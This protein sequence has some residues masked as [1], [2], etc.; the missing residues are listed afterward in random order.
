MFVYPDEYNGPQGGGQKVVVFPPPHQCFIPVLLWV[1]ELDSMQPITRKRPPVNMVDDFYAPDDSQLHRQVHCALHPYKR[2]RSAADRPALPA[3]PM[4]QKYESQE[5]EDSEDVVVDMG[6]P[7]PVSARSERMAVSEAGSADGGD[8][9]VMDD[10][11]RGGGGQAGSVA[12]ILRLHQ[13]RDTAHASNAGSSGGDGGHGHGSNGVIDGMDVDSL[14]ADN[15][16]ASAPASASGAAADTNVSAAPPAQPFPRSS[17]SGGG[18]PL[19]G[20][21][22]GNRTLPAAEHTTQANGGSAASTATGRVNPPFETEDDNPRARAAAAAYSRL[23]KAKAINMAGARTG[24]NAVAASQREPS[25]QSFADNGVY[26]DDV[27]NGAAVEQLPPSPTAQPQSPVHGEPVQFRM[28]NAFRNAAPGVASVAPGVPAV[29]GGM[30]GVPAPQAFDLFAHAQAAAAAPAEVKAA[31]NDSDEPRTINITADGG[32]SDT[33]AEATAVSAPQ[34]APVVTAPDDSDAGAHRGQ[35][36][37][38]DL[39]VVTA[40][41]RPVA[42]SPTVVPQHYQM[43]MVPDGP[44]TQE[45]FDETQLDA[46]QHESVKT[47]VAKREHTLDECLQVRPHVRNLCVCNG[48]SNMQAS[49][50]SHCRSAVCVRDASASCMPS[51]APSLQWLRYTN[52][53]LFVVHCAGVHS[54]RAAGRERP[55]GVSCVPGACAG[56]HQA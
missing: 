13:A 20:R 38:F 4:R 6:P 11:V 18:Q 25:S 42:M 22:A 56:A 15:A 28:A 21:T 32:G 2:H 31:G 5:L 3:Q 26:A 19:G 44:S 24:A 1:H 53:D 54:S 55:V 30:G 50:V 33:E 41:N 39:L 51:A 9:A 16:T 49:H 52:Q 46:R 27:A 45:F 23:A 36:G 8:G 10:T 29:A 40:H 34:G 17:G 37:P 48:T 14:P 35:R 43:R 47:Q 12:D 7:R